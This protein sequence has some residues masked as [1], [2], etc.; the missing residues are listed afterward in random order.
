MIP[1]TIAEIV[2]SYMAS[3][4]A[5]IICPGIFPLQIMSMANSQK[6]KNTDVLGNFLQITRGPHPKLVK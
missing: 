3:V 5:K 4:F 1:S 6:I 2:G